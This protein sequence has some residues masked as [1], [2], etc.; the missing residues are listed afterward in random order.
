MGCWIQYQLKLNGYTQQSVAAEADR[1]VDSVS[2][3]LRG[4]KDSERVRLALCKVLD[5]ENFNKLVAAMPQECR[6]PS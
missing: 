2:H 5:Y 4:R 6:R 1:S 3:F